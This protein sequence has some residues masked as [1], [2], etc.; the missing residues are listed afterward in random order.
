MITYFYKDIRA[1]DVE[2][3]KSYRPGSWVCVEHPTKNEIDELVERFSLDLGHMTDALDADEMPRIEREGDTTYIF[4]RYAYVNNDL[5]LTT[6]PL[7]FV[8][9]PKVLITVALNSLPRLQHFRNGKV[10]FSTTQK[11]KLLLQ[12]LSQIVDQYEVYINNISRRIKGIRSRLRRHEVVNQ[13]FIDFVT[14]EDELNEFLSSLQ[15]T[16]AILRRLLVGKHIQLYEQD[17]DIVEDL[18]LNNEQSIEACKSHVRSIVNIREA[19]ATITNNN[20]NR[21]MRTLTAATVVITLPNV[22]YGMFGMNVPLPFAHEPWAYSAIVGF[23]I[24]VTLLVL[25][26]GR[27]RRLF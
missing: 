5:E 25:V 23:T 2:V 17:Q 13:D 12:V 6:A 27:R 26:V 19:H 20:L 9:H 3:Q 18:L 8:F 7:L 10:A 21:A 24:V 16:T 11:T 1:T 14:I 15:P 4:V 22:F